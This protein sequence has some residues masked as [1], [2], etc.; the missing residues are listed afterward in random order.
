MHVRARAPAI[1]AGLV[2]ACIIPD[3]DIRFESADENESAVRIVQRAP[4]TP[5][6][7]QLCNATMDSDLS[8][9]PQVRRTRASG[10]VTP[11]EGDFCICPDGDR[12]AIASF[13]IYAEDADRDG[14]SFADTVYGV[15]LVDPALSAENPSDAVG[16]LRYW[17]PGRAGERIREGQDEEG[18]RTAPPQGR[19]PAG[20]WVFPLDDSTGE[21]EIDL[22]NRAGRPLAVGLHTLQFMVTD[23]PFFRPRALDIE[24]NEAFEA[25]GDPAYGN[26]QWGVP[27]LAG[28]ATYATI[29]YVF[30]CRDPSDPEADCACEGDDEG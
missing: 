2:S 5:E 4:F 7:D 10:L 11:D 14:D 15:A 24:G 21:H 27:D 20:L 18:N 22:C 17:E 12:R 28:G 13:E 19:T 6:M 3:R 25:N 26:T 30:E 9:C 8:Y 23:R 16:Y 29:E 1:L